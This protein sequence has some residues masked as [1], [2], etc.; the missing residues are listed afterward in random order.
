MT[1]LERGVLITKRNFILA[2]VLVMLLL[3]SLNSWIVKGDML[4]GSE[5]NAD[6]LPFTGSSVAELYFG[7]FAVNI[8]LNIIIFLFPLIILSK[9]DYEKDVSTMWIWV[10]PFISII[11]AYIDIWIFEDNLIP[12]T[13]GLL[14]IG[15]SFFFS[16]VI[17]LEQKFMTGF[18]LA[19]WSMAINY[20][21]WRFL[22][23]NDYSVVIAFLWLFGVCYFIFLIA[24]MFH[25]T[26]DFIRRNPDMHGKDLARQI[27]CIST[28][29]ILLF[30]PFQYFS[31][32]W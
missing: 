8:L 5:K 28:T 14:L 10:I 17:I 7:T 29:A 13:T 20:L 30:I 12:W 1:W 18:L 4:G 2:T 25:N 26:V 24:L 6:N 23:F 32:L 22:D 3:I 19:L 9:Y 16:A 11:G 15:I 27:F 31:K 21:A